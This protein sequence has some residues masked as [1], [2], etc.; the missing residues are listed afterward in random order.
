MIFLRRSFDA[1]SGKN[2][3][4]MVWFERKRSPDRHVATPILR[5]LSKRDTP[6]LDGE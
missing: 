1:G 5:H 6:V 4:R 2:D 3:G